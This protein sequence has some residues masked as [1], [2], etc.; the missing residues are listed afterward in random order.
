MCVCDTAEY[1]YDH[2]DHHLEELGV[3]STNDRGQ[4]IRARDLVDIFDGYKGKGYGL[5]TEEELG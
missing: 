1:F 5:S 4:P 2:V 3:A